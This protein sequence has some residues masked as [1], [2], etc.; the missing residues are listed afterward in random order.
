MV[1]SN[2][3]IK[4]GFCVYWFSHRGIGKIIEESDDYKESYKKIKREQPYNDIPFVGCGP[5]MKIATKN[6][7][8]DREKVIIR[9]KEIKEKEQKKKI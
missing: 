3:L 6:Y 7:N 8:I 2:T 9:R 5:N 1:K 4:K